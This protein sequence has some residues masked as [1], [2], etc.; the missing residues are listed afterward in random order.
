MTR[1]LYVDQPVVVWRGTVNMAPVY[2]LADIT[3]DGAPTIGSNPPLEA[4]EGM[5]VVFGSALGK[6]DK[7]RQRIRKQSIFDDTLFIGYSPQGSLDGEVNLADGDWIEVWDER[8][9]WSRVQRFFRQE[10]EPKTILF[11]DYDQVFASNGE[12]LLFYPKA[13]AGPARAGTINPDTGLLTVAFPGPVGVASFSIPSEV[14]IASYLWEVGDGTITVG[15]ET[16]AEITATFPA[17]KRYVSLTVTDTNGLAHTMYTLVVARDPNA[18]ICVEKWLIESWTSPPQGQQLSVRIVSNLPRATYPDGAPVLMFDDE[19][20]DHLCEFAGWHHTD[21]ASLEFVETGAL[22][23][24]VLHCLDM[25]GKLDTL[26]GQAQILSS[27]ATPSKWGEI[28]HPGMY[29]MIDYL[30]RW[31]STALELADFAWPEMEVDYGFV[32]RESGA[33]TIFRQVQEQAR[34][35]VYDH[36]FTCNRYG[37][38]LLRADPQLQASADRTDEVQVALSGHIGAIRVV[39]Q[40]PP[41]VYEVRGGAVLEGWA[42]V[43]GPEV[44]VEY[45]IR[46]A[47]GSFADIGETTVLTFPLPVALST[48]DVLNVKGLGVDFVTLTADAAL[49]ATSITVAPLGNTAAE[50]DFMIFTAMEPGAEIIPTVF[51]IA[52][53][54]TPGQGE[55][56]MTINNKITPAQGD[57]NV[58]IGN[59]YAR[60]NASESIIDV[61]LA[62]DGDLDIDP[63]EMTWVTL[64]PF[65]SRY[66][67]QRLLPFFSETTRLL[68]LEVNRQFVYS[69]T[70]RVQKTTLRL[71]RETAGLAAVTFTG[72]EI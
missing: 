6:D 43:P 66:I 2:P 49:G 15:S 21:S 9:V 20:P 54:L 42:P 4:L 48:G 56:T 55:Q 63:A 58:A 41:R 27:K 13:N 47:A 26:A 44:E 14:G 12:G 5:T 19:E 71:E 70:G 1:Y 10:A 29:Q 67:P 7:G 46:P 52:P 60:L 64:G 3:F 50:W 31:H 8:R 23:D 57:L 36:V 32:E 25:G 28:Y 68:P 35:L 33:D 61:E 65:A 18:D 62:D 22:R 37:Q 40:R 11:K 51:C 53:G 39:H 16:D 72:E 34:S 38:L 17:G 59:L 45:T 69:K 24:T 30:L